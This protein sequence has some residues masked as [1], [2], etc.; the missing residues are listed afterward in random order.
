VLTKALQVWG[1]AALPVDSQEVKAAGFVPQQEEAFICNLLEH[2]F[3]IRRVSD[4]EYW[5]F[6]R[7]DACGAL[8]ASRQRVAGRLLR[9]LLTLGCSA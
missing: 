1:L 7:W 2:W 5:N 8:L 4:G 9:A 6:N 3:T